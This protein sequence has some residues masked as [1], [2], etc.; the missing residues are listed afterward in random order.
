MILA[1]LDSPG[2]KGTASDEDRR[3]A[4]CRRPDAGPPDAAWGSS[5]RWTPWP[6]PGPLGHAAFPVAVAPL[7]APLSSRLAGV[8]LVF[9]L[10]EGLDGR[11]RRS[12]RWRRC[13][14]VRPPGDR[15]AIRRPLAL[16][17]RKDRVNA[18]LAA[19][20]LPVP[21]WALA[22]PTGGELESVPR[23][24]EAAGEDGSVGIHDGSVVEDPLEL[25][26]ALARLP[27]PAWSRRSWAA[28]S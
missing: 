16:A 3:H 2:W 13:R 24:R 10:T 21:A 26:A 27:G 4:R 25:A 6:R 19:A 22:G 15:R 9:N 8:D 20:G 28:G 18:L 23:H 14:S 7:D 1:V 11:A 12:P 5:R 17:R